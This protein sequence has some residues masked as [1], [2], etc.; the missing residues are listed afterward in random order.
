MKTIKIATV[1]MLIVLFAGCATLTQP[2]IPKWFSNT[3]EEAEYFYGVGESKG[4]DLSLT[5]LDAEAEARDDIAR[6]VQ[7]KIENIITRSKQMVGGNTQANVVSTASKQ[8]VN[9]TLSQ[10]TITEREIITQGNKY[11]VYALAKMP[12]NPLKDEVKKAIEQEE[13]KKQLNIDANLQNQ[14]YYEIERLDGKK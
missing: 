8:I 10:I 4:D 14:L 11:I 1:F 2:S 13:I 5:K 6:Q 9:L 7:I 3:P 12:V